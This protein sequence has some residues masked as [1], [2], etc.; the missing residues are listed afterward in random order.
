MAAA[1]LPIVHDALL[2]LVLEV[3]VFGHRGGR[4][5]IEI[6]DA[7]LEGVLFGDWVVDNLRAEVLWVFEIER[8]VVVQVVHRVSRGGGDG[9]DEFGGVRLNGIGIFV[10]IGRVVTGSSH[11]G[12]RHDNHHGQQK[13]NM[14][15]HY[16]IQKFLYYNTLSASL[17]RFSTVA[18]GICF[19]NLSKALSTAALLK[20]NI[21]NADNASFLIVLFG[22][23]KISVAKSFFFSLSFRSMTMR[24]AVLAP[25]P[26]TAWMVFTSSLAMALLNSLTVNE[27]RISLAV[28]QPTPDTLMSSSNRSRSLAE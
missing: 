8:R 14:S 9:I 22:V 19:S 4:V 25:M 7:P 11:S 16:I 12:E 5:V 26:F 20:P 21:V 10:K 27:L 3:F 15:F 13:E 24:W 23:A 17:I 6:A 1:F 28:L 2:G 18:S